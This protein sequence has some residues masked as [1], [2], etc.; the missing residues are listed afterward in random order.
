MHYGLKIADYA[1]AQI[2]ETLPVADH[3]GQFFFNPLEGS[4][5]LWDGNVWQP[6]G[7]TTGAIAFAGTF[8]ASTPSGIGQV[9]T[10]TA[11]GAAV[12]LVAGSGLPAASLENS[13]YYLVVASGGTITTGNAP[14]RTLA[15]PD[16]VL[17]DG[18]A[19][20]EVDVSAGAGAIAATNVSFSSGGDIS[21]TSVQSAIEEVSTECRNADNITSGTLAVARGGTGL[22]SYTKGDLI[23]ASGS[24]HA[25]QAAS[26]H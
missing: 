25:R 19:W 18:S 26:W 21:A 6:V 7:V 16:L 22:A 17:S 15:P 14:F 5:Y 20:V 11:A 12:G 24:H 2:G 8:D 3:I 4:V 9:A 13:E 10:V 23:A 1:N